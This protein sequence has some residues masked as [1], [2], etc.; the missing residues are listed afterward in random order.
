MN[1]IPLISVNRRI[2]VQLLIQVAILWI[3]AILSVS[4]MQA[5]EFDG[6]TEPFREIDI[7]APEPEG[8]NVQAGQVLSTLD[9]EVHLALLAIAAQSKQKGEWK[10]CWPNLA[11][12]KIASKNSRCS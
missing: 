9:N 12:A 7:A 1:Q 4:L 2:N 10:R 5:A 8:E 3:T 11:S 6:F